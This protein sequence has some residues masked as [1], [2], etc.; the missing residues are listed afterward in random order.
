LRNG[1]G[2][3]TRSHHTSGARGSYDA[4]TRT[5]KWSLRALGTESSVPTTRAPGCLRLDG[6]RESVRDSVLSTSRGSARAGGRRKI[7]RCVSGRC[8]G[9]NERAAGRKRALNA[10]QASAST[11]FS[12]VRA[13]SIG[14]EARLRLSRDGRETEIVVQH[15]TRLTR[16]L[17]GSTRRRL[18]SSFSS[19]P[20]SRS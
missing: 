3:R 1:Y 11:A 10:P 18:R 2:Q 16:K 12:A 17:F 14:S 15:C 6:Y 20:A 8:A 9:L 7:V 19:R 4:S 5:A 13:R